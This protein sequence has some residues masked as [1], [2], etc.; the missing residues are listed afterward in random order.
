METRKVRADLGSTM[1][2]QTGAE[3]LLKPANAFWLAGM[4]K[5]CL[6]CFQSGLVTNSILL[7][8]HNQGSV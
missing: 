6:V 2:F 3:S 1:W 5:A 4:Q 8:F 7:T